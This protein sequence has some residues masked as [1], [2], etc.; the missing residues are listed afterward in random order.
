MDTDGLGGLLDIL[1]GYIQ[2]E[3]NFAVILYLIAILIGLLL[4]AVQQVD[5]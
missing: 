4:P 2:E 3:R 1:L 5:A